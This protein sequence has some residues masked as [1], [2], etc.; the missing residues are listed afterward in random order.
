MAQLTAPDPRTN[1][2]VPPH[3]RADKRHQHPATPTG[4]VQQPEQLSMTTGRS[5][6]I[7]MLVPRVCASVGFLHGPWRWPTDSRRTG[8]QVTTYLPPPRR[9]QQGV[10]PAQDRSHLASQRST[11][12]RVLVIGQHETADAE[13]G[14]DVFQPGSCETSS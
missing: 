1:K 11:L 14:V 8:F 4:T 12:A 5:T 7:A 3:L 13:L 6:E 9:Q 2:H 10:R